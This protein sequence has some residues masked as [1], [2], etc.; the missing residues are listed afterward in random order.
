MSLNIKYKTKE[1]CLNAV[2]QDGLNIR[3][4]DLALRKDE[5]VA[6]TAVRNDGLALL[7]VPYE[8]ALH[9]DLALDAVKSNGLAYF[10]LPKTLR[11]DDAITLA[12]VTEYAFIYPY[13][14]A[15]GIKCET[16][17]LEAI[18]Q[19]PSLLP[20]YFPNN[21]TC[22]W[23]YIGSQRYNNETYAIIAKCLDE[24]K[25]NQVFATFWKDGK[26]YGIDQFDTLSEAK[27][28]IDSEMR[29]L[30]FMEEDRMDKL[31]GIDTTITRRS[32]DYFVKDSQRDEHP[33][34]H[35]KYQVEDA[36]EAKRIREERERYRV[37]HFQDDLYK[38]I[39][40]G[41]ER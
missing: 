30:R 28:H 41:H 31:G 36:I 4:C 27:S 15:S 7:Y 3:F 34:N 11:Q 32:Y 39:S 20:K 8:Y 22:E 37:E 10:C 25:N 2:R 38:S 26:P 35:K 33:E 23:M 13:T 18:K 6:M 24:D 19:D 9:Y 21:D 16:M 17:R 1:E 12:A 29:K 40:G 5:D 14:E